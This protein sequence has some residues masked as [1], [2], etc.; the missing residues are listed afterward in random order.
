MAPIAPCKPLKLALDY[1][2]VKTT[3]M[4]SWIR[5][6]ILSFHQ[7]LGPPGPQSRADPAMVPEPAATS[8]R[9]TSSCIWHLP[10][11]L[12]R[13]YARLSSFPLY[14]HGRRGH[15]T[16]SLLLPPS[17]RPAGSHHQHRFVPRQSGVSPRGKKPQLG[18]LP[19]LMHSALHERTP[20]PAEASISVAGMSVSMT[21]LAA[22]PASSSATATPSTIPIAEVSRH[23]VCRLLGPCP[24]QVSRD[25]PDRPTG[26]PQ[27]RPSRR[28]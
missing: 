25:A 26:S 5:P 2:R 21:C 6:Q 14:G 11:H 8:P 23:H 1:S 17:T 27:G 22:S 9:A 20:F 18:E 12:P 10:T 13:R 7:I 28:C 3:G 16:P 15:S 19:G 4:E 24:A